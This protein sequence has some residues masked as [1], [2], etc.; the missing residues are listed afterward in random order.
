MDTQDLILAELRELRN[1]YNENARKTGERLAK[2]E[3]QMHDLAGNGQP[4]RVSRIETAVRHLQQWRW[5]VLG[6]C[7][8]AS[9]IFTCA[10]WAFVH[11]RK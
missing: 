9:M 6:A 2:L 11:L 7:A 5:W 1:D 4:G 10:A 3:E 8:S